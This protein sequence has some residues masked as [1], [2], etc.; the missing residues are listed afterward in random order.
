[1]ANRRKRAVEGS[2]DTAAPKPD[3]RLRRLEQRLVAAHEL[4]A[5][6]VRQV[7]QARGRGA[8]RDLEVKR[9]R[10]LDKARRR[11]AELEAEIAGLRTS[12]RAGERPPGPRA[13]CLREKRSVE[14]ADPAPIV[15]RNGRAGI[16][17]TCPSCGVRLVRPGR[18]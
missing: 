12:D 3:R 15:M 9:R 14:I 13:W 4:E 8:A 5:K 11:A 7:E 10:Q 18:A 1:M 17:G 16:A 6:R 2:T